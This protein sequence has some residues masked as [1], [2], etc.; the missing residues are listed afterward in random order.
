MCV[1]QHISFLQCL[2]DHNR[3]EFGIN[4]SG[5]LLSRTTL[6]QNLVSNDIMEQSERF[7]FGLKIPKGPSKRL[8][9]KKFE[10]NQ[11]NWTTVLYLLYISHRPRHPIWYE[12]CLSGIQP[13]W[14]VVFNA[15]HIFS[16]L[17]TLVCQA[18]SFVLNLRFLTNVVEERGEKKNVNAVWGVS[19]EMIDAFVEEAPESC[20]CDGLGCCFHC[21]SQWRP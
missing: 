4:I 17:P 1:C 6:Q 2:L 8:H 5:L 12:S 9:V 13:F 11:L 16:F 15:R 3:D 20:H 10:S 21:S 7:P 14:L 18:V 19:D